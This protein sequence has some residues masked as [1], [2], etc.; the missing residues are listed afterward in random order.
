MPS[1]RE[2]DPNDETVLRAWYEVFHAAAAAGR[3][4]PL[5]SGY[6]GLAVSLRTPSSTVEYLTFAA[7]EGERLVGAAKLDFPLR[8][9]LDLVE[10]TL[11][12]APDDR[13]RGIGTALFEHGRAVVERRGRHVHTTEIDV[14]PPFAPTEHPGAR[15]ALKH[16]FT[17]QHTEERMVLALPIAEELLTELRSGATAHHADYDFVSWT[18]ACPDEHVDALVA[19]RN[20]ME[21]DVP[22]GESSREAMVWDV[23][24]QRESEQRLRARGFTTLVTAARHTSGEFA[25]YSL[26]F[27]PSAPT[28]DVY[29]DDTL[30]VS[31]HRGHRLGVAMKAR[32]LQRLREHDAKRELVHTWTDPDNTPMRDINH[33]FGFES[34]EVMHEFERTD[35]S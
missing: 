4:F 31:G 26:M 19:M 5:V 18:D 22:T 11:C 34:V 3:R 10:W 15:F 12:V 16:G 24:R 28:H 32:N 35:A 8:E 14:P 25:G 23:G 7:F 29:Q 9:N 6:Q 2:I 33:A 20:V 17:S 1:I 27:M 21:H 30:V 13:G